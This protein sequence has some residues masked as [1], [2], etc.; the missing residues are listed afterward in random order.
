MSVVDKLKNS[1]AGA[2]TTEELFAKNEA[3]ANMM[4]ATL[5]LILCIMHCITII[6]AISGIFL[7]D[8]ITLVYAM[9]I[10]GMINCFAYTLCRVYKGEAP[11]L[12][13][14]LLGSLLLACMLSDFALNYNVPLSMS[15]PILASIRYFNKKSTIR[16]GVFTSIVFAISSYM[17]TKVVTPYLDL[18]F[19]GYPEGTVLKYHESLVQTIY[20]HGFNQHNY[21]YYAMVQ[22]FL[23][24]LMVYIMIAAFCVLIAEKGRQMVLEEGVIASENA[25][26]EEELNTAA[27]IQ[28]SMLNTEFPDYNSFRLYAS[29]TPAK[30]VGG[31]FYDF[32]ML[33]DTHVGIVMADVS[34]KGVPASLF[35]VRAK[36]LLLEATSSDSDLGEV[37]TRVN[38]KL[39]QNNEQGLFVTAFEG[40]LDLTTGE[41]RYVNAGHELP[42]I[43]SAENK[44]FT[45]K[46]TKAAFVL[47]GMEGLKY[48]EGGI[49][50]LKPGDKIFQYTD[51]VT[52]ATDANNQLFGMER[53]E[54]TLN[55]Y[56]D[57]IPKDLLH[58]VKCEIDQF[59]GEAPQFDDLTMLCLEF[60]N[61]LVNE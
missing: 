61:Y 10:P 13:P 4:V 56:S 19:I 5:C 41:F 34:G 49:I 14:L 7:V 33:D 46:Q 17:N 8:E 29:M 60:K 42:F 55:S 57:S 58:N 50:T 39:C 40:I 18:N 12:K 6:L 44:T 23:P 24:K 16:I 22:G 59:V 1:M 25:R 26:I 32:F 52:E 27:N 28:A 2:K 3:N 11:W 35:M 38:N 20:E 30:E 45:P 9:F 47:G 48:K 21:T 51:G 54:E 31:D 53:L 37:F 15:V 43:Y 36:T